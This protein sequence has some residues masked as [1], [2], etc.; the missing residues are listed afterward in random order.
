MDMW[1]EL[2]N[3][4]VSRN[5]HH[6]IE[7][8]GY[9]CDQFSN[10]IEPTPPEEMPTPIPVTPMAAIIVGGEWEGDGYGLNS[11]EAFGCPNTDGPATFTLGML[12]YLVQS[13][14]G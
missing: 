5:F 6:V 12:K 13:S 11:F 9:Y 1:Q 10:Q 7:V 2:G 4:M 8:P 3:L 14:F